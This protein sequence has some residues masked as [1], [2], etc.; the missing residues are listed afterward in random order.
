MNI[1]N[2]KHFNAFFAAVAFVAMAGCGGGEDTSA[3]G[4]STPAAVPYTIYKTDSSEDQLTFRL[5]IKDRH[6]KDSLIETM[7]ELK[8]ERNWQN[9]LVCYF[10]MNEFS[11]SA[12]WASSGYLDGCET[13]TEKD[14][15]GHL[16]QFFQIGMGRQLAD[17]LK[18]LT[19]DTIPD[20]VKIGSYLADIERVKTE[21]YTVPGHDSK[22]L[23]A[24]LS[25]SGGKLLTWY[26]VKNVGGQKKLVDPADEDG[27]Y[28]M[29]N[30][31]S[32][33]L[34][35]YNK[36]DEVWQTYALN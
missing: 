23:I 6:S 29:L 2:K 32:N 35:F 1:L 5:I 12:A 17:S 21:L 7:R 19:L 22:V 33:K 11:T 14:K 3:A 30:E 13:C 8:A 15:D 34:E 26:N 24:Q 36:K 4:A 31:A 27:E 10:Y 9:K 20:K 28:L 18:T 16:V 25:N